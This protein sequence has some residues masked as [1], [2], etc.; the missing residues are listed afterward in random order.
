MPE[1]YSPVAVGTV[2]GMSGRQGEACAGAALSP[3]LALS[4]GTIWNLS[5]PAMPVAHPG[6]HLLVST[7]HLEGVV[8]QADQGGGEGPVA[9]ADPSLSAVKLSVTHS[10]P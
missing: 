6:H 9:T 2:S 7:V 3:G 5:F 8:R 10:A 4:L 1:E